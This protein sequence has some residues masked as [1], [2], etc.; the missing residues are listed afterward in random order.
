MKKKE[1]YLASTGKP[2][3]YGEV[4]K[5]SYNQNGI[6]SII[7]ITLNEFTVPELIQAGILLESPPT[8][9]N[10]SDAISIGDIICKIAKRLNW[11]PEK[12]EGFLNGIDSI[13]PMAAFSIVARELAIILDEKY[14][15]HINKSEKIYCIS[16]LDGRIHELC[17]AH[18]KNY[19]NFAAF[20]TIEDAKLACRILR[21]PLKSMFSGQ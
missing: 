8:K 4:I 16:S 21:E 9:K 7:Y 19:R 6:C 15:D 2:V 3:A 20:R 1:F 13:M 17:K 18:I 14:P 12:V 11:K 5:R 10:A